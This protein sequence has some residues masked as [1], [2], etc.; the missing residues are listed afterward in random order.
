M[1]GWHLQDYPDGFVQFTT[2]RNLKEIIQLVDEGRLKVDPITTHTMELT[3]AAKAVDL[4][5]DHADQAMGVILR[6]SH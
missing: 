4:L 2:Q 6:M 3:E 5:I 1:C